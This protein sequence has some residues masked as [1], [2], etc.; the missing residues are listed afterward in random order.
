[1]A[2]DIELEPALRN[3]I[4]R[5]HAHLDELDHYTLLG[6][7]RGADK[8]ALKAAFYGHVARMHPDRHFGKKLGSYK[9]KMELIFGRMTIA[10][11]TLASP[12]RRQEYDAYLAERQR[13][14]DLERALD[15]DAAF[16]DAVEERPVDAARVSDSAQPMAAQRMAAP[17]EPPTAEAEKARR[18]ALARRLLGGSSKRMAAVKPSTPTMPAVQ[19]SVP[20]ATPTPRQVGVDTLIAS[21]RSAANAG[22]LAAASTRARLAAKIDPR[23]AAEADELTRR[24]QAAMA[25]GYTKQAR[26]EESEERWV[27]AALSWSKANAGKPNDPV[28]AER[29]ANALRLAKGDL[30]KAVR[31]A[32]LA[33]R[34]RANDIGFRLTLGEVYA[35]AGLLKRAR[36]ELDVA[37]RLD[38]RDER[39][40][41]LHDELRLRGG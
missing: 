10:H 23:F 9:S 17:P 20:L 4:D 18:E 21:A 24:A 39:A 3:E 19:A 36:S 38:P 40:R 37:L 26:F 22:D 6:A 5:L 28:I 30:H 15:V 2:D 7:P 32:E 11:D 35:D 1:M 25:D 34:M 31:L 41:K 14:L 27:A 33:A 29:A 12:Q 16:L 8:K 13:L